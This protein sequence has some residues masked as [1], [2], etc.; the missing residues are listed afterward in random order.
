MA[1]VWAMG[2]LSSA[3]LAWT[4]WSVA[5]E[6]APDDIER[7]H[8]KIAAGDIALAGFFTLCSAG[9][10]LALLSAVTG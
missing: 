8:R 1:I 2:F 9:A 3:V 6:R 4:A 7:R 5:L 10:G